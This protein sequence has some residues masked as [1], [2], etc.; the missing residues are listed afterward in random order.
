[1]LVLNDT[2]EGTRAGEY[3]RG[4]A[5]VADEVGALANNSRESSEKISTLVKNID[6]GQTE[7][8]SK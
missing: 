2:I 6:I 8:A 1:M 7:L 3:G 4:F 5:V